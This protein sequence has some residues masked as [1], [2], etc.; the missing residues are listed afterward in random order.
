MG[1]FAGVDWVGRGG[2]GCAAAA[3]AGRHQLAHAPAAVQIGR[4]LVDALIQWA[5][6]VAIWWQLARPKLDARVGRL[7]AGRDVRIVGGWRGSTG[8]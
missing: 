7:F 3:A 5:V 1:R 8:S 6:V 4:E 2:G